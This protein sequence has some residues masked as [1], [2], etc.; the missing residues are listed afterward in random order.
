VLDDLAVVVEA[1]DVDARHVPGLVVGVDGDEIAFGD[2]AVHVDVDGPD[3]GEEFLDG[4]EPVSGLGVVLDVV[5]DDQLVEGVDVA[6]AKGVEEA[7]DRLLVPFC[8][9]S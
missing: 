7:C 9:C 3:R 4:L 1:E 5:L 6:G 8:P 2:H